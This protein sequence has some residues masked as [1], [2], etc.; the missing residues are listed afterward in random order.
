MT[1]VLTASLLTL[2]LS[3]TPEPPPSS[4][5][6]TQIAQKVQHFYD[7]MEDYTAEFIQKYTRTALSRTSEF[8]GTLTVKKGGKVRWA[9]EQPAKK[10]FVANGKTLWIYEPEEEQVI[11]NPHF[12]S[13]QIGGSSLAFLWGQ[14]ELEQ[15]FNLSIPTD[16]EH[17]FGK[18]ATVI[19][20]TPKTD[21]TYKQL[22]LHVDPESGRVEGSVVFETSGNTRWF[23]F[24]NPKLNQNV[25][26]SVFEFVPPEGVDVVQI[27]R[28]S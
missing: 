21:Q 19:Q 3:A 25:K 15:S 20:L 26:D 13:E 1:S 24:I 22:I 17:S 16:I 10:L 12:T 2:T 18:D 9:Y 11:V 5:N 7:Q 28:P 6:A 27:G 8:S 4:P 23:K 14:G